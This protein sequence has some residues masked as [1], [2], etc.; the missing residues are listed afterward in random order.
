MII[1][2]IFIDNIGFIYLVDENGLLYH[3]NYTK[4]CVFSKKNMQP[5]N[6]FSINDNFVVVAKNN[7]Y[8]FDNDY[9][10]TKEFSARVIDPKCVTQ[11]N[12][13]IVFKVSM[14]DEAQTQVLSIMPMTQILN[15]TTELLMRNIKLEDFKTIIGIRYFESFLYVHHKGDDGPMIDVLRVTI[16]DQEQSYSRVARIDSF[17]EIHFRNVWFDIDNKEISKIEMFV[18]RRRGYYLRHRQDTVSCLYLPDDPRATEVLK[19]L[20]QHFKFDE[21]IDAPMMYRCNVAM[22]TVPKNV[23]VKLIDNGTIQVLLIVDRR[24]ADIS[25]SEEMS[26]IGTSCLLITKEDYEDVKLSYD[27]IDY[28]AVNTLFK[29]DIRMTV[30]ITNRMPIFDQMICFA[31]SV[32]FSNSKNFYNFRMINRNEIISYGAGCKR[33]L[34]YKLGQELSRQISK[35]LENPAYVMYGEC[36][37]NGN[38]ESI[39]NE[40]NENNESILNENDENIGNSVSI[41][42]GL[43]NEI[44]TAILR[45]P[46]SE[47]NLYDPFDIGA[48]LYLCCYESSVVFDSIH[49]YFFYKLSNDRHFDNISLIKCFC[50]NDRIKFAAYYIMFAHNKQM[51]SDLDLDFKDAREYIGFL[52]RSSLSPAHIKYIDKLTDGFKFGLRSHAKCDII[53]ALPI[54]CLIYTILRPPHFEYTFA[55]MTHEPD[56]G[57]TDEKIGPEDF[58]AF[59]IHFRD[60]F[61][62]LTATQQRSVIQNITGTEFFAAEIIIKYRYESRNESDTSDQ[63]KRTYDIS[64]CNAMLTF[65]VEPKLENVKMVIET[66]AISDEHMRN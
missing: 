55:F 60:V 47:N 42:K 8:F 32:Y 6:C 7:L 49:P 10:H 61:N 15:A 11:I 63:I 34:F 56:L 51:M 33:Q 26:I 21:T 23:Y 52:M 58:E 46:L 1:V 13:N 43:P 48:L 19:S 30:D 65:Y 14:G 18:H 38:N 4:I 59:R 31:R 27:D 3:Y 57:E 2:N 66:L 12:D 17:G 53:L 41:S 28:G 25:N 16:N 9:Y 37:S 62:A 29:F 20:H 22:F 5:C 54:Q 24:R 39:L 64:T 45:G 35:V 36:A 40:N 50:P 44:V